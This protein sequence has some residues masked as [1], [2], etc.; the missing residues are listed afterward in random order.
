M[1]NFIHNNEFTLNDLCFSSCGY[2]NKISLKNVNEEDFLYIEE[3]SRSEL[4]KRLSE[5]CASMKIK[6]SDR[7]K[8][9]FFG[10]FTTDT[11]KFKFS[12]SDRIMI[13][14]AA[15][16]LKCPNFDQLDSSKENEIVHKMKAVHHWFDENNS[17]DDV[18][19]D[20]IQA[21]AGAQNLMGKMLETAENNALRPKQGYRNND[22]F[23]RLVVYNRLL[24]GPTAYKSLQMN[25]DGCF[26]SISTTNRYIHRSDHAIVEGVL[27]TD[28]LSAYLEARKQPMWVVLSEDATRVDNRLQY[29]SR[30]N[31]IIGFVLPINQ[32][33]GMPIPFCF[34]AR[35]AN[36]ILQHFADENSL[37]H[38]VN[39][40]MAQPLGSTSSFCLLVFGSDSRYTADDVSKRWDFVTKELNKIGI[41]VLSIS[42]DSDPKYSCAM[43]NN[44]GLG[45]VTNELLMGGLFKC[46]VNL[47]PPYYVQDCPHI[48][49]KL[50]NALL[51]TI[52]DKEKFPFGRYHIQ[53]NHLQE[54]M[55]IS[56]KDKHLLTA[57]T[58]NPVDRQNF[59]S[60]L[61]ICSD[62][63]INLLKHKVKDSDG[64]IIFLQIMSDVIAAFMDRKL[65]PI[66]RLE[67]MWYSVFLVR[68]WKHFILKQPGL[69]L[70]NNFLSQYCYRCIEQNAHSIVFILLY[71]KKNHLTHLFHPHLICSQPCEAFFRQIRSLTTVN[72]T[73][74]NCSTKEI[75]N[76]ISRIQLLSEISNDTD[77]GFAFP[78]SLQS[79]NFVD[80]KYSEA[81]F[82][83]ESE[84][85]NIIQKCKFRAIE[86]AERIGLIKKKDVSEES[87][88]FCS[89]L[90]KDSI[91]SRA[92]NIQVF[93]DNSLSEIIRNFGELH[94]K[95]ASAS[96]KNFAG[97]FEEGTIPETS[98]YVEIIS[99][100]RRF[101]FKKTSLCGCFVMKA[102]NVVVTEDTVL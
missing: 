1:V 39:V 58:L 54:L 57:T 15:E 96:L 52:D 41:G 3:F 73:V 62:R 50:R 93:N 6:L 35:S 77:A 80:A 42:S 69:T 45:A 32:E 70:K 19:K 48:G 86:T 59:E 90:P 84:M 60:V 87:I 95:L 26:P 72:S 31:Q 68:I 65:S 36:E 51:K 5:K 74:V 97:K 64:T 100:S 78:K 18:Q 10:V 81:Q 4:M 94:M 7:I 17:S 23:K 99:A 28:E 91:D 30:T 56:S 22:D 71:L 98:S 75:L 85:I 21:P 33:N 101:V 11:S 53:Q 43:R 55:N 49:T 24:S 79:S 25:L 76:R 66:D 82:P 20:K 37:A 102:T 13:H 46:G 61:K 67:K 9:A 92:R 29:D 8:T 63:V 27:R 34:K 38:F 12:E 44:S 14:L 88:Y 2:S 47:E 16:K 89:I 40:I 83:T